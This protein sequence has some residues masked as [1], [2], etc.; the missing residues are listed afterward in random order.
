MSCCAGSCTRAWAKLQKLHTISNWKGAILGN[1]V[2]VRM[3]MIVEAVTIKAAGG[4]GVV[5]VREVAVAGVAATVGDAAAAVLPALLP[6][7][8]GRV[9]GQEILENFQIRMQTRGQMHI[10]QAGLW[11]LTVAGWSR[12]IPT[13]TG[14]VE[15]GARVAA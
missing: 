5:E 4:V 9:N 1:T 2:D 10:P 13:H 11:R 15:E 8:V 7:L 6:V 14:V 3:A 12:C